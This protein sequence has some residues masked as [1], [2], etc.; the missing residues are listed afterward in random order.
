MSDVGQIER[1]T[2]SRVVKLF[3]EQL[4]YDY[5][6]DWQYRDDNRNV[7]EGELRSWMR[8]Q[9]YDQPLINKAVHKL[10]RAASV[11][12]DEL[13]D[14]NKKVYHMLRYGVDVRAEKG[15]KK[16]TVNFMDW[17][18]PQNNHFAIAEEVSVRGQNN[19]RPDVVLYL[20][21]IA[22]GVLE[23]KRSKVSVE[24]GIR[25]NLA[26]QTDDFIKPFF[27]TMQLVMAG[28]DSVGLRYGT[29]KTK[30]R[31]YQ[32]WKEN[33]DQEFDYVL[34]KHLT[35]LCNKERLIEILH[36]FILFDGGT[37]IVCRPHQYFGV[38]ASQQNI[39]KREDGIIWHTQGSGKSL[40]MVWLAR[41]IRENVTD[42]R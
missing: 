20:N 37:K 17:Q 7:E 39:E 28:N 16:Q 33:T 8:Q 23:L 36:D 34:D 15:A 13:Y 40:T 19:K 5:L 1:N 12:M 31:F 10:R 11:Q 25:Q 14:S 30:D 38:K 21:G 32:E 42:S 18:H 26:N 22:V 24:E 6:G 27:N 29:T 35:Q 2:Q 41:W 3:Q 9:G 4:G